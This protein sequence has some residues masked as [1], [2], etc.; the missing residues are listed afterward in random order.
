MGM[1]I[2]A[3]NTTIRTMLLSIKFCYFGTEVQDIKLFPSFILTELMHRG[4]F[5]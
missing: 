3:T 2:S 4:T 5:S 1:V